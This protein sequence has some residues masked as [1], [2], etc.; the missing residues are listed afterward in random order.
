VNKDLV[1]NN[2]CFI[3]LNGDKNNRLESLSLTV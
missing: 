2:I 3:Y 1:L